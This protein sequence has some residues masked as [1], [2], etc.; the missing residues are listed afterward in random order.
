[1]AVSELP[2]MTADEIV[3]LSRKYTLYEWSAQ[4][5]AD[6]IPV[7]RAEGSY[8]YTPDG[9]RYL[10]FNSQLMS[11]NIGHGDKRVVDAIKAQAD[12]LAYVNPFMAHEPRARLGKKLAELAPG[13]IDVFFFTNGGAEANENAIKL[14]RQATG[15]WKVLARYRS[16]HG[17]TGQVITATGDPR[18]WAA[19][20]GVWGVVRV[21]DTQPW[22]EPGPRPVD[23]LLRE[24]ERVILYEGP[25]TIA[26]LILEPV[27]GTNGILIPPDGYMQGI[28]EMCDR[29]GIW[30]IADEVMTGFGRTGKWWAV[31]H[32]GVVPDLITMAK[33]L[34]SSY[35]PLGAVGMR[36][37]V[38]D[39]FRDKVFFGGLTYNSHPMGC[40]A[41]L[42]TIAV[43]EEDGLIERAARMGDVLRGHHQR[44]MAK[45]PSVGSVRNIGMFGMIDVVRSR[46]PYEPMAPYNGTSDEMKA[47]AKFLRDNGLYTMYRWN[48]IHTN[49]PLTISEDELAEGFD[50]IDRALDISDQAVRA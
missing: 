39:A 28:R 22:G 5:A 30:L 17:A 38:A 35:L 43:Y 44:L 33:G 31:D 2:G 1:M 14:A 3:E 34:T 48:G 47:I 49:P 11:V 27:V 26:A 12:K 37:S 25:Q 32:W 10:D 46:S 45:H 6:P 50:L 23:E 9:K 36:R 41:A 19:E 15:R 8:F 24:T 7:D 16:Y 21:P 4:S 42:A 18:R 29:Y 40:A 20:N 13:D